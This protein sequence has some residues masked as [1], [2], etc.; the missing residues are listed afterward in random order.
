MS[1]GYDD[2]D[3]STSGSYTVT[4]TDS[5]TVASGSQQLGVWAYSSTTPGSTNWI[6]NVN[7]MNNTFAYYWVNTGGGNGSQGHLT[8]TNGVLFVAVSSTSI[9]FIGSASVPVTVNI[10][11]VNL[12]ETQNGGGS[13][14]GGELTI[15]LQ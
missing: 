12:I 11:N 8:L 13:F 1:N 2:W 15:Q 9:T 6:W 4:L 5:M 14:N 10:Q 3:V 7:F